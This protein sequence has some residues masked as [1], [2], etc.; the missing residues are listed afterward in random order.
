[1]GAERRSH[2]PASEEGGRFLGVCAPATTASSAPRR[3][4]GPLPSGGDDGRALAGTER[5]ADAREAAPVA[6]QPVQR[7]RPIADLP[8]VAAGHAHLHPAHLAGRARKA[9][10]V[11]AH[12]LLT[13]ARPAR[14]PAR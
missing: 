10:A 5:E 14:P 4:R 8:R 12:S 7:R 6:G 2:G 13:A 1:P 9:R 3:S 11:P